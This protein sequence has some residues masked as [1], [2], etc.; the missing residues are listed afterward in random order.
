MT[1][2][3]TLKR[4]IRDRSGIAAVEFAMVAPVLAAIFVGIAGVAPFVQIN[5]NMHDALTAGSRYV[6]AGGTDPSAIQSV[7]ISAWPGHVAADTVSVNQYCTCADLQGSCTAL[8]TDGTVPKGYTTIQMSSA[9]SGALGQ[10]TLT[11]QQ[12]VRTR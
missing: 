2:R 6:M 10:Q 9:Y 3:S 12:T 8:C 7:T 4:T 5:N 11:A 1:L